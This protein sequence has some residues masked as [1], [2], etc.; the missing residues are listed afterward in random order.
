M[1]YLGHVIIFTH[2]YRQGRSGNVAM[3]VMF[4]NAKSDGWQRI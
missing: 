4:L 2:T 3:N 1:K